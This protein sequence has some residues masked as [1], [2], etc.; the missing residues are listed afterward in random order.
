M[1]QLD[2]IYPFGA[3]LN[4]HKGYEDILSLPIDDISK[5]VEEHKVLILRGFPELS[6]KDF[7]IFAEK[8]GPLLHWDFG[9]VLDLKITDDAANHIF[10][11]GRVELHWDGA[12]VKEK[13]KLQIFQCLESVEPENGGE[14]IFVDT[15][16]VLNKATDVEKEKWNKIVVNYKTEKKAHYGGEISEPLI[17]KHPGTNKARI[18][19]I[20][21]F[22]EDNMDVNPL[23][24]QVD[25]CNDESEE[26]FLRE[27][28]SKLYDNDVMYGHAWKKGDLLISDNNALL[29]GRHKF[30]RRS[31][32]HLQRVHV[33]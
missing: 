33:L 9:P 25:N 11:D 6:K 22:N 16:K 23:F 20:E 7:E 2:D 17:S 21:P 18:R 8:F 3:V 32:R 13:P 30:S 4:P 26:V 28:T 15:E 10:S 31:E 29:H 5:L 1:N 14:T 19:F 12:F 24:L 27:F